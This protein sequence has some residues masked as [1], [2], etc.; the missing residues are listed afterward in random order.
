MHEKFKH[1]HHVESVFSPILVGANRIRFGHRVKRIS[2][3]QILKKNAVRLTNRRWHVSNWNWL[4][5]DMNHFFFIGC[6]TTNWIIL[7]NAS[8]SST[9]MGSMGGLPLNFVSFA[10][11][12]NEF[13]S[14]IAFRACYSLHEKNF[15]ICG[16]PQLGRDNVR[17][18][19]W[20]S[21][22][23]DFDRIF[24]PSSRMSVSLTVSD[25]LLDYIDSEDELISSAISLIISIALVTSRLIVRIVRLF[26]PLRTVGLLL[27][28]QF[29][30]KEK[31]VYFTLNY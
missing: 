5:I 28:H 18:R 1:I 22:S 24:I 19:I 21:Q 12:P 20:S 4:F 23:L 9:S 30:G 11:R 10:R 15:W 8:I 27:D 13:R 2:G 3:F 25:I 6:L 16:R 14:S 31:N 7:K 26:N 29:F 17:R